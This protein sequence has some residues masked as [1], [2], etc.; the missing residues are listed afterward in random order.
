MN[1]IA[2]LFGRIRPREIPA[3]SEERFDF[4]LAQTKALVEE[5]DHAGFVKLAYRFLLNL[6]VDQ[7]NLNRDVAYLKR[8]S[9]SRHEFVAGLVHSRRG[10][11]P[12]RRKKL[13]PAG[14]SSLVRLGYQ[15]ILGRPA[16]LEGF[17]NHVLA[18]ASGHLTAHQFVVSLIQS[19][20]FKSHL[21]HPGLHR[22]RQQIVRRLPGADMI[23]DLGGSAAGRPEGA[24]VYMGY[25][26]SF[27]RLSIVEPPRDE[28][29]AIYANHCGDYNEVIQTAQGPVCYVYKSMTDLSDF[30]DQSIDLVYSGQSIEHVGQEEAKRSLREV[31]RI[32]K[33]GGHFCL[34][35][36]NR[37]ITRL[38]CP[39]QLINPDH[40]YEYTHQEL[41]ALLA[42]AGFSIRE[43]LGLCWTPNSLKTGKFVIEECI[44]HEG[45]YDD[46]EN[47][48]LLYYACRKR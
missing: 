19:P 36:P 35:T 41:S 21:L 33:P 40:K 38:Q 6:R 14:V 2:G 26:H 46:F 9:L 16:D 44:A 5:L 17:N 45:L 18:I 23:V 27:K 28:R 10:G 25:P 7:S 43:V 32:L 39:D 4:E 13:T 11:R 30:A 42:E 48:Y 8:H 31:F 24:L 29:H 20:E 37:A 15:L 12:P 3:I 22:S 1:L 47:C 34:D